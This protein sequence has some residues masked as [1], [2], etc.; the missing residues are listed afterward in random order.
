MFQRLKPP[1]F[2]AYFKTAA[3]RLP[4][5]FAVVT[6]CDPRGRKYPAAANRAR[7]TAL[8]RRL[9]EAGLTRFRVTG[10][11][12]DGTHQEPGWGVACSRDAARALA[13]EFAQDAFYWVSG[14]RI[15]LGSA[16]GGALKR[17]GSW[18]ARRAR[19]S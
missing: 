19:W 6:A 14:D 13:A 1:Y 15:Y 12:E 3:V 16:A 4:R 11:S 9:D 8:R 5:R 7:D 10:G 17:A 2:R 18:K